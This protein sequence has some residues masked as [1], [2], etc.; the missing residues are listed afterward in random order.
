MIIFLSVLHQAVFKAN[1]VSPI[2]S[3]TKSFFQK[4]LESEKT[5]FFLSSLN[6]KSDAEIEHAMNN[7]FRR[8]LRHSNDIVYAV[9]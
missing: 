1:A 8:H 4:P 9:S 5:K 2:I 6:G 7:F 3:Q